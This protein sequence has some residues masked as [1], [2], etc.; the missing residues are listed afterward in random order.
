MVV[1]GSVLLHLLWLQCMLELVEACLLDRAARIMAQQV[2]QGLNCTVSAMCRRV[3]VGSG[4]SSCCTQPC[5]CWVWRRSWS[6]VGAAVAAI[7]AETAG[8]TA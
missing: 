1:R 4:R 8:A 2:T 6:P 3:R 7:A 5:A